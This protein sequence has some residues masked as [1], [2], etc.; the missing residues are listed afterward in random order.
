MSAKFYQKQVTLTNGNVFN[1]K[2]YIADP[3]DF[4]VGP[5]PTDTSI[6]WANAG[7]FGT[8]ASF[9]MQ[10]SSGKGFMTALHI[11]R[12]KNM[13]EYS[14]NAEG[15]NQNC[16]EVG[17][18]QTAMDIIYCN[19]T[20][21]KAGLLEKTAEWTPSNNHGVSNMEWGIGGINVLPTNTYVNE[22]TFLTAVKQYYNNKL[23]SL[24]QF[25][26]KTSR[27]A[28][29]IRSDGSIIL[30]AVFG[31]NIN[32]PLNNGPTMYDIHLLMK[33]FGCTKA[34]CLDGSS[35]TR[36]SY[37]ENG[38]LKGKDAGQRT[39]YCRIRLLVNVANEC[40]WDLS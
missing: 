25:D 37:K 31:P 3:M 36:I 22:S 8:N 4:C 7:A 13:A 34:L 24:I 26:T 9:F 11:F 40:T 1:T 32:V 10:Q 35:C 6:S 19:G 12:N 33:Y 2:F 18:D 5:A 28:I 27:T 15:G 16:A 38:T 29:G 39:V 23:N 14:G 20:T 21:K 17:N 30:V